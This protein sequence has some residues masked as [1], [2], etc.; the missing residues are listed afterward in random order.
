MSRFSFLW[1]SSDLPTEVA[2]NKLL[3]REGAPEMGSYP[4]TLR[5][6]WDSSF[7]EA[8]KKMAGRLVDMVSTYQP[9]E[10]EQGR[11]ARRTDLGKQNGYISGKMIQRRYLPA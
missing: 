5:S 4:V 8:E 3:D 9:S 1:R 7:T 6:Y 2:R 11:E 10:A